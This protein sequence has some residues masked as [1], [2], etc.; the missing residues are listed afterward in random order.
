MTASVRLRND[1]G[2]PSKLSAAL[3]HEVLKNPS[4]VCLS[5]KMFS[6]EFSCS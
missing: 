6:T 3:S 4:L 5:F 1:L 2:T